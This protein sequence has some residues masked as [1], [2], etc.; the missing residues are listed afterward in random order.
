MPQDPPLHPAP[1]PS[2]GGHRPPRRLLA[3]RFPGA[4]Q[5]RGSERRLSQPCGT[6]RASV[7]G[8]A[9]AQRRDWPARVPSPDQGPAVLRKA[10][11]A[12]VCGFR[13]RSVTSRGGSGFVRTSGSVFRGGHTRRVSTDPACAS[14]SL[15][16]RQRLLL[17]GFGASAFSF[18][19]V[20]ASRRFNL[21]F[22][23]ALYSWSIFSLLIC[24]L[25]ILDEASVKI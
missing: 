16:P 1:C 8:D 2:P 5:S 12:A 10:A 19:F 6:D 24:H 23:D 13:G 25:C 7:T 18:T 20:I 15:R 9:L 11:L 17:S 22:P 4:A 3:W 21:H 14:L